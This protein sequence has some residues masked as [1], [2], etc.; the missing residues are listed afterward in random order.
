MT[1]GD[2]LALFGALLVV[3]GAVWAAVKGWTY[4]MYQP[5]HEFALVLVGFALY[6]LA[7]LMPRQF[8]F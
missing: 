6:F 3:G 7:K 4:C 2:Y 5:K 8:F 1:F